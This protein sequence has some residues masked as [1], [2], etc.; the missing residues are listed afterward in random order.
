MTL[1]SYRD[2]NTESSSNKEQLVKTIEDLIPIL[3]VALHEIV[4]QVT[5]HCSERGRAL[6]K[7]WKT[8]VELFHRVLRQ[9]KKSQAEQKERTAEVRGRLSAAKQELAD[10]RR[11]HP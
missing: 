11:G 6:E 9:M 10:L 1:E 8:Y 5:H 3:S 2:N 7:L 4:R